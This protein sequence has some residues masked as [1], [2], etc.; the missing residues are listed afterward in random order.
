[1]PS[2]GK[3]KTSP[4]FPV[5]CIG[6]SAGSLAAYVDILKQIPPQFGMAIV[7]ISHRAPNDG[8]RFITLLAKVTQM[9]VVEA[10]D[11]MVIEPNR[12]FVAPARGE[13]TT[14]GMALRLAVS[15]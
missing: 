12:I 1:M 5:V 14:D 8:G 4:I 9:D 13:V 2:S 3:K 10:N 15:A 6:G 11:G 7:I